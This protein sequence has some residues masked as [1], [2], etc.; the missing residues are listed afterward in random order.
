M[1][2]DELVGPGMYVNWLSFN[3]GDAWLGTQEFPLFT[4]AHIV[5]EGAYGPYALLNP[6]APYEPG[7]VRPGIILRASWH[8]QYPRPNWQR[9]DSDF[10]HGGS[11]I[12]EIAAILSLVL[13]TRLRAGWNSRDFDPGGNPKGRPTE[14]WRRSSP[15]PH[16]RFG[17]EGP[18][19]PSATQLDRQIAELAIINTVPSLSPAEA[20]CLIRAARLYQDSLWLADSETSLAWVMLVSALETAANQWKRDR[21]PPVERLKASRPELYEYLYGLSAEAPVRV[22]EQIVDSLGSAKKF[23]DFV[24]EFLPPAPPLRPPGYQFSWEISDITRALRLIYRYRSKALHDGTPFPAPMCDSPRRL[25]QDWQAWT[26]RP[27]GLAASMLGSVWLAEDTPILFHTFEY[28]ARNALLRWWQQV[29][30]SKA[31]T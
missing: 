12:E 11:P 3:R 14:L 22:A 16:F 26:E 2:R 18:V 5:G 7:S 30:D 10:Y 20:I 8:R 21:D 24:K 28:I 23:V 25:A 6:V 27:T 31:V 17:R 4:D 19:V 15:M 1:E 29:M 9:T 13:G